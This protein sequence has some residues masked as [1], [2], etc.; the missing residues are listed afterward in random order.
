VSNE[1]LK[2]SQYL[3]IMTFDINLLKKPTSINIGS[4]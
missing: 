1:D 4:A 3:L 2:Y